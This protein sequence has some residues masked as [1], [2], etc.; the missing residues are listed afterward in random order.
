[1]AKV[2]KNDVFRLGHVV[3]ISQ[4]QITVNRRSK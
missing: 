1:M 4:F 3:R 2:L